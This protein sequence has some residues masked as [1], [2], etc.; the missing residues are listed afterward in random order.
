MLRDLSTVIE[1]LHEGL[2]G[3]GRAAAAGMRLA[4]V[5]ITL[6]MDFLA[7]LRDGTCVLLADVA[8]AQSDA[9][10]I[11]RASRARFVWQ[12]LPPDEIAAVEEAS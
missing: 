9:A 10:W 5:E 11:E 7:V 6:P 8:R 1:D 4:H 3:Y 2:S 12:L